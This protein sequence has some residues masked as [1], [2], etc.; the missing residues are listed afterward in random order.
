MSVCVWPGVLGIDV[1]LMP[2]TQGIEA[3]T[4]VLFHGSMVGAGLASVL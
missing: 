1:A 3:G 4:Q 2:S